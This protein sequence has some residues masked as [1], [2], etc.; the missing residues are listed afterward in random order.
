MKFCDLQAADFVKY[1]NN[2]FKVYT[3]DNVLITMGGDFTYQ[4]GDYYFLNLD[5]L[6]R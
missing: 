4:A 5:R 3:T 1:L 2:V 6:M